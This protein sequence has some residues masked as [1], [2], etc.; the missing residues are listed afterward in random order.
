MVTAK[1]HWEKVTK[2]PDFGA[3]LIATVLF[4]GFASLDFDGFF[5]AFT[6][7]NVLHFSAILGLVALGQT[8]VLI[9]KE[10]DLSVGSVYGIGGISYILFEPQLGVIG[11]AIAVLLG[12]ALIGLIN[13]TLILRGKLSA[14]IV[15]LCGLF[16]YRGAIY[17]ITGGG[18]PRFDTEAR[19]HWFNQM[20]GGQAMGVP[21]SVWIFLLVALVFHLLLTR[22]PFGN[23]LYAIGGDAPS[24][25]SRGV[26]ND[27][28]KT[29]AFVACS[30]LAAFA[31]ILTIADRP[32]TYVS[33]GYQ[34]ELEAI[35]A[36][37]VGGCSLR[38][39]RGTVLG[40]LL[41]ALIIV[42]VRY[43]LV[44]MGAP[45][46]WFITFVGVLLISVV[47]FNRLLGIWIYGKQQTAE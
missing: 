47:V 31:G 7:R 16:F 11:A 20:L 1:L 15:T 45:S 12:A 4:L 24:A 3:I 36:A 38:G 14:V 44:G 8:L 43:Q 6:M 40:A 19:V 30:M 9:V 21:N 27:F 34:F 46:S 39:G 5:N 25:V 41:G 26:R 17:L 29:W 23:R 35:A 10:V 22:T 18:V 13:A 28:I 33:M 37:I 32:Q 42:A 2:R